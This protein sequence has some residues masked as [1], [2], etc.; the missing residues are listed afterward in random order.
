MEIFR[1]KNGPWSAS[2]GFLGENQQQHPFLPNASPDLW[3][4]SIRDEA[5][6]AIS[7]LNHP[8][9]LVPFL[10]HTVLSDPL[11]SPLWREKEE[12]AKWLPPKQP[13]KHRGK[14]SLRWKGKGSR[15]S[16]PGHPT[17]NSS[18]VSWELAMYLSWSLLSVHSDRLHPHFQGASISGSLCSAAG[19]RQV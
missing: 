13:K 6:R 4:V 10:T 8:T 3:I 18:C 16:V 9:S 11:T 5:S 19:H 14:F 17:P 2:L 15:R 7:A 12:V 1:M